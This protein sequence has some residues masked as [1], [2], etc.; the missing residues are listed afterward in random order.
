MAAFSSSTCRVQLTA[1]R[2]RSGRIPPNPASLPRATCYAVA[3]HGGISNIIDDMQLL[4]TE[5]EG[6]AEAIPE[7]V[8]GAGQA[9]T[10]MDTS[11]ALS[12]QGTHTLVPSAHTETLMF[13]VRRPLTPCPPPAVAAR[14]GEPRGTGG[15]AAG[16]DRRAAWRA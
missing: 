8:R 11:S 3:G 7:E 12:T 9:H 2:T 5:A 15:R 1:R 6:V 16:L 13:A 4:S 14:A 10:D